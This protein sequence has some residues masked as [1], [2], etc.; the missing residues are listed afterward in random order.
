MGRLAASNKKTIRD[1]LRRLELALDASKIGVWEHNLTLDMVLW[2]DQMHA[3]YCTAPSTDPIAG[4]VWSSLVHPD[5]FE[6]ASSEFAAAL[7]NQGHYDSRFRIVWPDGQVRHI[8]S[9]AHCYTNE[10][11][12]PCIIGAEWD[13]TDHV[14]LTD[15]LEE[16]AAQLARSYAE[17]EHAAEH[18]YLTALPNRRALD[19]WLERILSDPKERS[20]AVLRLDID[21]F[22]KINDTWG[23]PVGDLALKIVADRISKLLPSNALAARTGGDEFVIVVEE[24]ESLAELIS[25]VERV[26]DDLRQPI[27]ISGNELPNQVSIGT[28]WRSGSLADAD[29]LTESDLALDEA[30]R[31]GRNQTIFFDESIKSELLLKRRL[32][33]ELQEGLRRGEV[34][35]YY[36]VQVDALNSTV[37]GLEALARWN[38]PTRGLLT[39]DKFL[40]VAEE[41]G[42]IQDIDAAILQQ[43]FRDRSSWSAT[44]M[45]VP[46]VAVNISAARLQNP[47]LIA[48]LRQAAPSLAGISVEL[49]ETIFL[50]DCSGDLLERIN[51]LREL[52]C[53]I[54]ID[55]FGSGHAS[56]L[57][58]MRIRPDRLK[59]DRNLVQEGT[60]SGEQRQVI[61]S[62]V[63]IARA[64]NIQIIAEGVE[65]AEQ[66]AILLSL[67]CRFFQ[68][69]LF[70][71][72]EPAAEIAKVLRVPVKLATIKVPEPPDFAVEKRMA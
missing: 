48:S 50:D 62:I 39:P 21:R 27:G 22:K 56:L 26:H 23:Q 69:Y 7:S 46:K 36:Q 41:N 49:L 65:T 34:I 57:G 53:E 51:V 12:E 68:G 35:P 37:I 72:P 52:G 4:H 30:K 64:L 43:V 1:L 42:L 54:E 5:D 20:L 66:A 3:L 45:A 58:L 47:A 25:L 29:L 17:A 18:D 32:L 67:G 40:P 44:G 9:R 16:K 38:H 14:T 19:R 33:A 13:V 71:R 28:A 10:D 6:R 59:L 11:E 8:Q 61:K 15:Q 31:R 63:D 24:F 2:D 60:K 55:D 70:G